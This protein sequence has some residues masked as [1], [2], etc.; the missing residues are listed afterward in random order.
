MKLHENKRSGLAADQLRHFYLSAVRP[1]LEYCSVMWHHGLSRA[2]V[3]QLEAV[4][5]RAVRI[6][7]KITFD[8]PYQSA[9][10]YTNIS[11]LQAKNSSETL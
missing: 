9:L 6:I 1:I 4:Q 2:Q 10:A 7:F 11:S 8:M 3:E 5:R